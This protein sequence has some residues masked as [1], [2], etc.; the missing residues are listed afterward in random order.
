MANKKKY[1]QK[2][3]QDPGKSITEKTAITP[4]TENILP[5]YMQLIAA[6]QWLK[7]PR[8]IESDFI[9]YYYNSTIKT[10]RWAFT[11]G[12][13]IYALFGFTGYLCYPNISAAG[14]DNSLWD[15]MP[16]F[17]DSGITYFQ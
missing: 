15:R 6:A 17:I 16:G 2:F 12:F 5:D 14:L 8:N 3:K 11:M 7:F 1:E 13:L 10:T 4:A 9:S